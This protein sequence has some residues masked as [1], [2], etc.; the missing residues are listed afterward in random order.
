MQDIG[1]CRA[2]VESVKVANALRDLPK[3]SPSAVSV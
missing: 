2:V 1:G 3:D